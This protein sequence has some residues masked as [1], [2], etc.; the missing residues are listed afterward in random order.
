MTELGI[1]ATWDFL[2]W[3]LLGRRGLLSPPE[4][5]QLMTP[6]GHEQSNLKSLNTQ[7]MMPVLSLQESG[8][9]PLMV[10]VRE[11]RLAIVERLLELGVNP[12][13]QTKVRNHTRT[14]S[15][16]PGWAGTEE[17]EAG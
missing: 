4:Q 2:W 12:S 14:G 1:P 10:A 13:E 7:S 6:L 9:T 3:W 5:C 16:V 17:G 11:N 15:A 8:L